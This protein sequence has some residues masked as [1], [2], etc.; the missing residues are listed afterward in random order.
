MLIIKPVVFIGN[1]LEDLRAFPVNPRREVG[2]QIDKV[3]RGGVPDNW[4]PVSSIG[5]G[6]Y[7][8]RIRDK[9]GQFRV[10]YA[11]KFPEVVYILHCFIKRLRKLPQLIWIWRS[12]DTVSY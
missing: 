7:E 9:S 5:P 4:K 6:V 3:Q 10:I 11:A 12:N 1:S 8:I 2:Y